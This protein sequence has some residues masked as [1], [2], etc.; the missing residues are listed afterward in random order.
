M[1]QS[2]DMSEACLLAT[3][4]SN[5]DESTKVFILNTIGFAHEVRDAMN[6]SDQYSAQQQRSPIV[7]AITSHTNESQTNQPSETMASAKRMKEAEDTPQDSYTLTMTE[8]ILSER[9]WGVSSPYALVSMYERGGL[10]FC[11]QLMSDPLFKTGHLPGIR[12]YKL[13]KHLEN[14][15]EMERNRIQDKAKKL[16]IEVVKYDGCC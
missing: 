7:V 4:Q 15:E 8:I 11:L 14:S 9:T 16:G 2:P 13:L 10:D 5:L 1:Q 3:D 12:L 6:I